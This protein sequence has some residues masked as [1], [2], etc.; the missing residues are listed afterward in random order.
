M[1]I[2]ERGPAW[3]RA[4]FN[5]K[6]LRRNVVS[7]YGAGEIRSTTPVSPKGTPGALAST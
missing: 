4:S 7:G 2:K 1:F 5:I 3:R 6:H